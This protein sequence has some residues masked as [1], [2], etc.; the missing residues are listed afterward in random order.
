MKQVTVIDLRSDK[1]RIIAS[2]E[3]F[4]QDVTEQCERGELY[5]KANKKEQAIIDE[6]FEGR[7]YIQYVLNDITEIYPWKAMVRRSFDDAGP[8]QV[9]GYCCQSDH[10]IYCLRDEKIYLIHQF[11]TFPYDTENKH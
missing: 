10:Y 11:S 7:N 5:R 3:A 4:L 9:I 1:E 8:Y 2:A 6:V